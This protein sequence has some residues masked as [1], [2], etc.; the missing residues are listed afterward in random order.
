MR[1]AVQAVTRGESV[2][3]P[4][5]LQT[6]LVAARYGL[7]PRE[8]DRWPADLFLEALGCLPATGVVTALLGS[9]DG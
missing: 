3:L 9:G 8:V 6:H 4:P 7:D 2:T 5:R 1:T